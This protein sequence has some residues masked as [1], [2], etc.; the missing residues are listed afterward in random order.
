MDTIRPLL[1]PALGDKEWYK[2]R[3]ISAGQIEED[4]EPFKNTSDPKYTFQFICE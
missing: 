1:D 2:I 4:P 3:K